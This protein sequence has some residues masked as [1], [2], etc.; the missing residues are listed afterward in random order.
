M[1]KN[2]GELVNIV[3]PSLEDGLCFTSSAIDGFA[4]ALGFGN[5]ASERLAEKQ[6]TLIMLDQGM[7]TWRA[8]VRSLCK[9]TRRLVVA[10][11]EDWPD[12]YLDSQFGDYCPMAVAF[13][14]VGKRLVATEVRLHRSRTGD[15]RL[16]SADLTSEYVLGGDGNGAWAPLPQT[17][18][19]LAFIGALRAEFSWYFDHLEQQEEEK[20]ARTDP[21]GEEE[22]AGCL[23][24][25]PG[26]ELN[27]GRWRKPATGLRAV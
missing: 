21:L 25:L 12:D 22:Q 3:W 2:Y 10:V 16:C 15:A 20:L 19:R 8:A 4:R 5:N 18:T 1:L 11:N 17:F 6:P 27:I 7:A 26:V 23:I 14:L 13:E 24:S 9:R